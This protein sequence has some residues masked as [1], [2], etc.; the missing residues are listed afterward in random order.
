M[1]RA[2]RPLDDG[3]SPLLRFAADLRRLRN[4]AGSPAYRELSRRAHYSATALSDAAGGRRLPSLPVTLAYVAA[5]G[6]NTTVWERRWRALA[7]EL[8]DPA[9]RVDAADTPYVGLAMFQ[10]EDAGRFFGRERLVVELAER[11][12]AQRFVVVVGP[13]GSGKSSL[14]RAGLVHHATNNGRRGP[15]VVMTPGPHP[16]EECAASLATLVAGTP[17]AVHRALRADP[18]GLHRIVLQAAP[19]GGEVLVVVDQFEET[20]TLC[21][22]QDER[23]R[24]LTVLT[25]AAQAPN[26]RTRIVLGLRADFYAHCTHHPELV[27]ALRD[28]QVLVGPMT[29]EEL[30]AAITRPALHAG[31]RVENALVSRIV[32]DATGRPGVLPLVSHALLETW[33]RRRGT[34]LTL[35]GYDAA[36]GITQSIARTAEAIHTAFTEAQQRWARQLFVR[37]V[38]LGEGTE[39]T[40]RRLDR[41]EVDLAEPFHAMVVERL[42]DARLI[43]LDHD[44][45]EITHEA[46]IRSWP[47]L[48]T[49]L[50][51]DRDG[52]R[53]HRRLTEAANTWEAL[54]RDPSALYRGTSLAQAD[55]WAAGGVGI[56]ST[57]EKDFLLASRAAQDHDNAV[58][59]RG[60]RRVR[61]LLVLL[62]VLIVLLTVLL[63]LLTV[64]TGYALRA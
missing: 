58:T 32:A 12:T 38:T 10:Q 23:E 37:L 4:E 63:V 27:K 57:R 9:P 25:T 15:I 5:C 35:A 11:V 31:C 2:E 3:D 17:T 7:A 19:A 6:G 64:A 50:T 34:T 1:P 40:R 39:D 20:F 14:L 30:R 22:D 18:R 47:R 45:I 52:L 26:S 16:L 59:R 24:F 62:T 46:L 49:W 54:G 44:S 60:T 43:T 41:S 48:H 33:R 21:R 8:A 42:A 28:G 61:Q 13:S 53:V 36:G 56:L 29:T 55:Q 51:D